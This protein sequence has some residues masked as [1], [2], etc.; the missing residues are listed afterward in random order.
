MLFVLFV[1]CALLSFFAVG[2]GV[3]ILLPQMHAEFVGELH[4]LDDATFNQLLAVAQAAPGPNFLLVP[5]IG[6]RVA[7]FSGAGVALVAFLIMP[8][9]ITIAVGRLLRR[10]P[11]GILALVR[12]SLRPLTG[13]FWIAAGVVVATH[14][15]TDLVHLATTFAVLGLATFVELSPLWWCLLGGALCAIVH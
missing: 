2:G 10:H 8:V 6:F 3:S 12:R 5:L 9:A 4:W 1:R 13:G 14:V 15:D 11:T 7:G